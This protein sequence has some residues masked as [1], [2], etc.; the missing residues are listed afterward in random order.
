MDLL[1]L[2][3]EAREGAE[4]RDGQA[5]LLAAY[6]KDMVGVSAEVR[7]EEPGTIERSAGKASRVRDLRPGGSQP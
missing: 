4:G 6:L 2:R 3:V 5:R 1:V 7:V